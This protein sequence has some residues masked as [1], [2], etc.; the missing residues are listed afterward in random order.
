M[1]LFVFQQAN[2]G[3]YDLSHTR[4]AALLPSCGGPQ[5]SVLQNKQSRISLALQIAG[6]MHDQVERQAAQWQKQHAQKNKTDEVD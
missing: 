5:V 1:I 3:S 4:Q 6:A 2:Y